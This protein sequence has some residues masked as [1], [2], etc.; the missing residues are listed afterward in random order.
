MGARDDN[1]DL[2]VTWEAADW[3]E[4]GTKTAARG[5]GALRQSAHN[6]SDRVELF[7]AC[8]FCSFATGGGASGSVD[9]GVDKVVASGKEVKTDAVMP[10][11]PSE[12]SS[13]AGPE[14]HGASIADRAAS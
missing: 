1:V 14:R 11:A 6:E 12:V 10:Y 7:R 4:R 2:A 13:V 9:V 5:K 3:W 8:S